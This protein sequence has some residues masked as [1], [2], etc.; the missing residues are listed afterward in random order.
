MGRFTS[1]NRTKS[2]GFDEEKS[3]LILPVL[4][5]A[6]LYLIGGENL[7]VGVDEPDLVTVT[8]PD[9]D[10]RGAHRS[11]DVAP[12]ERG[13]TIRR[14][15]LK[16]GSTEGDT[17]L[18]GMS[19]FVSWAGPVT[20]RVV[21]DANA[22]Q[23][24]KTE[25]EATAEIRDELAKLSLRDAVLRV[26]ED[27][28]NSK[29]CLG[30]GFGTYMVAKIDGKPADWCGGFSYWCWRQAAA[31]KGV[32][33]PIGGDESVLWSPQRAI[34]WAM[35][36]PDKAVLWRYKGGDPGTHPDK[37]L[38]QE[39]HDIG[40]GGYSLERG[41]MVLLRKIATKPGDDWQH[42]TML[43]WAGETA[44]HTLDGNVG[45]GNCIQRRTYDLKRKLSN[46]EYHLAFVHILV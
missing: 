45:K 36:N 3:L 24:G 40:W 41:D 38:N 31:I 7:Q 26:G 11:V 46:G 32:A 23:V 33:N 17:E 12:G 9:A 27:Q 37:T 15:V 44:V 21:H 1:V 42:V 30:D 20:I 43:D 35:Q 6:E 25:G 18:R 10:V 22:R 28:M 39:F 19:G 4:R 2:V 13:L 29:V 5:S 34:S 16:A 14:V 8:A